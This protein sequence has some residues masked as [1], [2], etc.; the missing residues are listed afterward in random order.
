LAVPSDSLFGLEKSVDILSKKTAAK[1]SII[2][3]TK[4]MFKIS[5]QLD[6]KGDRAKKEKVKKKEK[7]E[8]ELTD[9]RI[10]LIKRLQKDIEAAATP[11]EHIV[12][13]LGI[14]YDILAKE[15]ELLKKAGIMRRFASILYHRNA[16]F[17]ANA[18]VVWKIPE[19]KAEEIGER[20]AAYSAVSHCYLRPVY[21]NWPYPLFSMI[22]GKSKEE[23][24]EVV[25][26]I[27][28]E[29]GI[30]EY[31]YLYSTREFKKQRFDYFSPKFREWELKYG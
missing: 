23:V 11:F 9:F 22:H 18:M 13:E 24:E 28:E 14:D 2:L 16:G 6:L 27:S 17:K 4:K 25:K 3:P 12:D 7:I 30:K 8:L 31:S 29:T 20:V 10:E 26:D 5:V 21:P 1:E 15:V 19:E